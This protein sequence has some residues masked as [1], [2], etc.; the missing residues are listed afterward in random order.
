MNPVNGFEIPVTDMSRAQKFYETLLNTE[1][2]IQDMYGTEMGFF[3]FDPEGSGPG[4][5]GAL[6]KAETYVPSHE[7][8]M[9]YFFVPEINHVLGKV[10]GA[11]GK[12]INEK[13]SIEENGFVGH[14][15]DAEGN[16]V[17]LHKAAAA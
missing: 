4:A 12:I 6:V 1:L 8:T 2:S 13:F 16:H 7:G 14:F 11:G 5:S 10:E 9:V 15:E 17:A 3:P